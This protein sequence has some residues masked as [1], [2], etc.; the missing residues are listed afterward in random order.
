[1]NEIYLLSKNERE[2]YFRT[3]ADAIKM[4]FNI[5]EKDYWVVWILERLFTLTEL[6][7]H[8]TFKGGTSL[9]KIYNMIDRFSEDID[10]SIEKQFFGFGSNNDPESAPSKNNVVTKILPVF[11]T[12]CL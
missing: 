10:L 7:N 4:P 5:I 11:W 8:L 6:K 12:T 9:S 1:M 3:A 2:I